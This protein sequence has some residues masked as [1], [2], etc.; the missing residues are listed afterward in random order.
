MPFD[1]QNQSFSNI[2]YN[3]K[4]ISNIDFDLLINSYNQILTNL[5]KIPIE[6]IKK[7]H[8]K[9]EKSQEGISGILPF[10]QSYVYEYFKD[11]EH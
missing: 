2:T 10:C 3:G 4:L 7:M 9:Y 1:G 8:D 11:Y 5:E 6:E